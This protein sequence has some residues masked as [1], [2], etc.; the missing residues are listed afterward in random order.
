MR[1][2]NR[3]RAAALGRETVEILERGSYVSA[4]GQEV[5]I[6]DAVDEAV[7]DTITY[8]PGQT[9]RFIPEEA[10]DTVIEVV[11]ETTLEAARRLC[12]QGGERSVAL[13]N[14][15]S[16]KHP[17]GGFLGGS[18]A[19]EESLARSS[20]LYAAL[21][22]DEMYDYHRSRRDAIYS[23]YVIYSP[24]VPV[25]RDDDGALLDE[26]YRC[27]F[28]TSPAAN[29]KA[30][31][32]HDPRR[33]AAIRKAMR[34]RIEKIMKVAAYHGHD[35]YVLGAWGCGAFGND[36]EEIAALFHEALGPAAFGGVFKHVVF[37]IIDWSN[38]RRFL[39]PFARAF[40]LPVT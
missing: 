2:M 22:G 36:A 17:G 28:V 5:S 12:T 9:V 40:G 1:L 24:G 23:D 19:Q 31:L 10:H 38:E 26:P 3:A 13:L 21:E 29:A 35:T 30:V 39:G 11:N 32:R 6:R 14:F 4:S 7:E 25:F 15:A 37:A 33:G 8:A 34:G 27:A 20:G 18:R 16:A